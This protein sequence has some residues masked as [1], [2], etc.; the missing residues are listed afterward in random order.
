MGATTAALFMRGSAQ[1]SPVAATHHLDYQSAMQVFFLKRWRIWTSHLLCHVICRKVAYKEVVLQG[2][3]V[4][5]L[6][7]RKPVLPDP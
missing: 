1:S 3:V 5:I 7:G 4:A 6:S 2:S